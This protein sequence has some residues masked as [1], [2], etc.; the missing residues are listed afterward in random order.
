MTANAVAKS[1]GPRRSRPLVV[2]IAWLLMLGTSLPVVLYPRFDRR[3]AGLLRDLAGR[4]ELGQVALG[5]AVHYMEYVTFFRTGRGL[6]EVG[7]PFSYRPLSPFIASQL[8]ISNPMTALN[9]VN[10]IC[11]YGALFSLLLWLRGLG[12]SL[13]EMIVGGFLFTVSFPVFYYGSD[14]GIDPA[15]IFLLT[16][17]IH[18]IFCAPW[19]TLVPV[20]LLGSATKEVVVILLPVFTAHR[21]VNGGPWAF[22]TIV[23]GT[24]YIVPAMAIRL[25]LREYG[26]YFWYPDISTLV[27]N[28]RIRALLSVL[29]TIGLPGVFAALYLRREGW[30]GI[31]DKRQVL[32][33]LLTGVAASAA[34][35]VYSM[36]SAFTD[37]RFAWPMTIFA[38]PLALWF[39]QARRLKRRSA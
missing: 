21:I 13:A 28:F 9:V 30:R 36:T 6:G 1:D 18:L 17:G 37:G 27:Y 10:A 19:W 5:D 12:F 25:S 39:L 3:E 35:I 38:I 14:G 31:W 15:F 11:L 7:A 32:A 8:P 22:G 34:L 29:L 23:L 16:L 26:S 20:L 2:R 33:P 4:D 24:A